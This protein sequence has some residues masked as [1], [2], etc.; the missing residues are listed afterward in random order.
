MTIRDALLDEL[1]AVVG[2][3]R[4][5]HIV[6][7]QD[8]LDV[9]D[10]PTIMFKQQTLAPLPEG[11]RAGLR[12]DY[13]LTFI[14]P[15]IDPTTAETFLDT[16]VPETLADLTMSWFAWTEATK[17][18]FGTI[19]PAYDVACYVIARPTNPTP[20]PAGDTLEGIDNG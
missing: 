14:A 17:V 5:V 16:W 6:P 8:N 13:V 18:V 11:P 1:R 3:D 20:A 19:N 12:V 10:R 2:P 9:P 15:D 4:D 7:Y